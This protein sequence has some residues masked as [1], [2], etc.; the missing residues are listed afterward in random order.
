MGHVHDF[1]SQ[2]VKTNPVHADY[3]QKAIG[4]LNEKELDQIE[5]Y[6]DFCLADGLDMGYLV[7][8][9]NTIVNDA[10][11][12]QIYFLRHGTYR[13]S[14]F[15][16]TFNLV[17][18]NKEYMTRYMYGLALTAFAWPNHTQMHEFFSQALPKDKAGS[19]LE[20]GPGHGY[21]FMEAIRLSSYTRFKGVDVSEASIE[22]TQRIVNYHLESQDAEI[23]LVLEDFLSFDDE[24]ERYNAIVMGEVLEHVE[25]PLVFLQRIRALSHPD[26]FIYVTTCV[27]APAID[28]I[29]LYNTTDEVE[30]MIHEAGLRIEDKLYA[31]YFGMTLEECKQR[32]LAINVAYVLRMDND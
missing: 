17:Y 31:P 32:R 28:H 27:N 18:N 1:A 5:A 20:V 25:N 10:I 26:T 22:L 19:Y 9:Y 12:E 8:S 11:K 24:G 21:Y 16:D 4:L 13:Y 15:C 2:V 30:D 29:Y 14:S 7:K 3:L 23:E 6:I